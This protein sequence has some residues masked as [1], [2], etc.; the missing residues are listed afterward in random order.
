MRAPTVDGG[1]AVRHSRT[2]SL[3]TPAQLT[4]SRRT[5][6]GW[7]QGRHP[8][9]AYLGISSW[10]LR[11]PASLPHPTPLPAAQPALSSA[12]LQPLPSDDAR[13]SRPEGR[14]AGQPGAAG[15]RAAGLH[16]ATH[17]AVPA[18]GPALRPSPSAPAGPARR[19]CPQLRGTRWERRCG[20]VGLEKE[21]CKALGSSMAALA[22]A[23]M[24]TTTS[25]QL[26]CS[27]WLPC[28]M[29]PAQRPCS[30]GITR[31]H[32]SYQGTIS[33]CM[34]SGPPAPKSA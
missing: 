30:P 1:R 10:M 18:W 3:T 12:L 15:R 7:L 26:Q 25:Q 17:G 22:S 2:T 13:P 34:Y 28:N 32:Q 11:P 27:A 23:C 5:P 9:N 24:R 19:R 14:P 8:Q 4:T 29:P 21:Q 33:H 20:A 16:G 6:H 31:L